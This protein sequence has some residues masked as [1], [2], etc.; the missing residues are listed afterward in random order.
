MLKLEYKKFHIVKAG[1]T[2]RSIA[3][4]Y[5]IPERLLVKMNGLTEEPTV[6]SVLRLPGCKGDYYTAQAG[7][8]P[9]LLCG[10]VENFET[11]N[12]G[13]ILYPEM[14]VWL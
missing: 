5:Q 10:S 11:K 1:Q 13:R 6:G 8:S 4:T 2:L 14:K 12:G 3:K 9:S 7:D